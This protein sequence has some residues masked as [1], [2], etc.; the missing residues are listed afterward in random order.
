MSQN[1]NL[2]LRI[3]TALVA[4]PIILALIYLGPAWGFFTLTTAASAVAAIEFFGMTH[5]ED[6]PS[7]VFGLML[8][9]TIAVTFFASAGSM[10][11]LALLLFLTLVPTLLGPLFSIVRVGAIETAALR[12]FAMSVGPLYCAVPI[13]LLATMKKLDQANGPGL[14]VLALMFAWFSDTGGYF[15]GRFLGKHKL[16]ERVSPKKTVEGAI[17]G[18]AAAVLGGVIASVSFLKVIPLSHAIVLALLAGGLGQAGDLAESLI[19]RSVGVKDSG[20]ILPGHGGILDRID[21]LLVTSTLVFLYWTFFIPL[22]TND[23]LGSFFGPVF[24]WPMFRLL[25][26]GSLGF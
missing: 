16:H 1:R 20:A 24:Q 26:G 25:V 12:A 15:A 17:G 5:S 11:F 9:L 7:R 2:V 8:T 13:T 10:W 14:V 21:A 22:S 18:L 23:K 19:K 4:V 3:A 6:R